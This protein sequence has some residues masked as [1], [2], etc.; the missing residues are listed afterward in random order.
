MRQLGQSEIEDLHQAAS[1]DEDVLGFEIPVNDAFLVSGSHPVGDLNGVLDRLA[2]RKGA[3]PEPLAKGLALEQLRDHVGCPGFRA[4][5]V[6]GEDI[7]MV[8]CRGGQGLLLEPAQPIPILGNR[9]REDL[10]R[11]LAA[12]SGVARAID[13]AHPA[14]TERS[15]DL[16]RTQARAG[17]KGHLE[18]CAIL[19]PADP[20]YERSP[21]RMRR[22]G[23]LPF[24]HGPISAEPR[25]AAR[26]PPKARGRLGAGESVAR[27]WGGER[28]AAPGSTG[29]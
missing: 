22:P 11:N 21:C 28:A 5:V 26:R 29:G 24:A 3:R 10:D 13:F 8:E 2:F 1:R 25:C 19:T 16:V 27:V 23:R 9:F 7:G 12:K 20:A 14:R 6:N 17:G 15:E 4:E 18:R